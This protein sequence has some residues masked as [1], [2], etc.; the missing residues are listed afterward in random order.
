LALD[1]DVTMLRAKLSSNSPVAMKL[2]Y[3]W[4]RNDTQ[5]GRWQSAKQSGALSLM[6]HEEL[7]RYAHVYAVL[8]AIMDALPAFGARMEVAGAIARRAPDGDLPLREMCEPCDRTAI[9]A[10]VAALA[11]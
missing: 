1:A 6:P 2:D 5:D 4:H 10:I 11:V 9:L 7:R 8:A 3:T